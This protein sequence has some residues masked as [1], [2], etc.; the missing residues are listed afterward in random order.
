MMT[1]NLK[2]FLSKKKIVEQKFVYSN[3]MCSFIFFIHQYHA[4]LKIF[5]VEFYLIS[6]YDFIPAFNKY[7]NL[8][9]KSLDYSCFNVIY[10]F[11][12]TAISSNQQVDHS[13][14]E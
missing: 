10:I 6:M 5:F 4:L 8:A 11:V 1:Q 14:F 12:P 9:Y 3:L 13:P 2:I 7:R